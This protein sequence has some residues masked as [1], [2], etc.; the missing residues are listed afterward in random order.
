[1]LLAA[2]DITAFHVVG[3]VLAIWAVLVAALG[4]T[5]PNFPGSLGAERVVI[6]ISAVLVFGA[7]GTGIATSERP[8]KGE[9]GEQGQ[10]TEKSG[11]EGSEAPDQGGTPAP[12]SAPE[13]GQEEAG[14][15]GQDAPAPKTGQTL[16]LA[17]DKTALAFD[18]DTLEAKAGH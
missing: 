15:T 13:S 1:M 11:E 8:A 3:A 12:S 9:E 10:F 7:I 17:A 14:A 5:R 2:T 18:T 4:I 16:K 6:V